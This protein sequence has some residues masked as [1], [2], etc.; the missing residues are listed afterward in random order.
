ML[1]Q[2][3]KDEC[4]LYDQKRNLSTLCEVHKSWLI[5]QIP[6]IQDSFVIKYRLGKGTFGE[7]FMASLKENPDSLYALKYIYPISSPHRI[8]NEIKCLSL[9]KGCDS[10]I[11]L[12]AFV[13]YDSHIVLIMPFIEHDKFKDYVKCGII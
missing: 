4:A 10:V 13:C 9:L 3:T 1:Q 12:E 5:D 2:D 8:E 7:V 11:S 6:V